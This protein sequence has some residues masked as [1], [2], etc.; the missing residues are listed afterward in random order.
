MKALSQEQRAKQLAKRG[1]FCFDREHD[2][3]AMYFYTK[4]LAVDNEDASVHHQ[5]ALLYRKAGDAQRALHHF[6]EAVRIEPNNALYHCNF[7]M[8]LSICEGDDSDWLSDLA[9]CELRTAVEL[10]PDYTHALAELAIVLAQDKRDK[11]GALQ[12][13]GLAI[14]ANQKLHTHSAEN[15]LEFKRQILSAITES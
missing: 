6:R 8:F 4:S 1:D 9:I 2:K 12:N 15:L 13:I 7:G 11:E 5:I 14:E 3:N 10:K